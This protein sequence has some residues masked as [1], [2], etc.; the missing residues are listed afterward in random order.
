MATVDAHFSGREKGK[1]VRSANIIA[2]RAVADIVRTS[3]GPKG[4]DKLITTADGSHIIT[5]DGATI[6]SKLDTQHPAAK[7]IIDLSRAQDVEAGDGT[8]SVVVMAGAILGAAQELLERGVHPS[9]ISSSFHLAQDKLKEIL[10]SIAQP[11]DLSDRENLIKA[12]IT[13]LNS[14][15]ISQNSDTLAPLAVDA[16]LRV[17]DPAT[18]V[19]VDLNQIK[20]IGKLGGTIDDTELV[21]G[22][23]FSQGSLQTSGIP[24][25]I[26]NAKIGLIQYQLSPPKTNME[27]SV[28]VDDYTQIDKVLKEERAYIQK[29]LRPIIKSGCNVLLIQK[30]ILRDAVSDIALHYLSS[31]KI[32]VIPDVERTEVDFIAQSLNLTPVADPE[33]FTVEK[34]GTAELI[35]E[36]ATPSGK[37]IK[38]TGVANPG[39]TVSILCRGSNRL[40]TDEAIRSLHDALCVIRSL[41]KYKFLITG[42][43]SPEMAVSVLLERWADTLNDERGY[44]IKEYARALQMVPTTLAEN[45]GMNPVAII[46]ELR[47]QHAAG[48][49]TMGINVKKCKVSDMKD[50]NVMQPLLVSLSALSLATECTRMIM[51][52]D[53]IVGVR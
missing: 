53:D 49:H 36:I 13:S 39:K 14:K 42:G 29:L 21:N 52:I 3:L 40:V 25:E 22:I 28:I 6:V 7:M 23:V 37:I 12:A 26:K 43:G 32:M 44:C 9:M 47:K 19:N 46:T 20:V 51:K 34:L 24:P 17:I 31:R 15:V 8:T 35:Q 41:V 18:A 4:M 45:S 5:N 16:V 1:D 33:D 10:I 50:E 11:I 27:N 38:V 30:S 48:N 2:A